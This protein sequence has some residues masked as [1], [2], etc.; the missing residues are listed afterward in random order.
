METLEAH[1]T[2]TPGM[3]WQV[4]GNL[5]GKM[6]GLPKAL[7]ATLEEHYLARQTN[8]VGTYDSDKLAMAASVTAAWPGTVNVGPKVQHKEP[9]LIIRTAVAR[10]H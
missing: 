6:L 5:L 2:K 1:F 10:V 8:P 3:A 7:P 4:S 9:N